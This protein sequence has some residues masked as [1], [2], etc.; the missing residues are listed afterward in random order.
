MAGGLPSVRRAAP[1]TT[2]PGPARAAGGLPSVRGAAPATQPVGSYEHADHGFA[3]AHLVAGLDER[4]G[5]AG[6]EAIRPGAEPDHAD[7]LSRLELVP[8][9][10]PAHHAA[11]GDARD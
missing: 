2:P 11:G 7:P 10:H 1:A 3:A 4:L 9:A 6:E 8:G 5:A